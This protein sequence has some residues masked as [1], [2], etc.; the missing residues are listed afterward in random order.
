MSVQRMQ[1]KTT[2]SNKR[3]KRKRIQ[4]HVTKYMTI[5]ISL[6]RFVKEQQHYILLLLAL[7]K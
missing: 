1:E 7:F 5:L 3:R 2:Y 4:Q 6:L